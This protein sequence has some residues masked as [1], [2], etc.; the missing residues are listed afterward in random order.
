L[1]ATIALAV[2]TTYLLQHAPKRRY[3]F[4]TG[5]PFVFALVTTFTASVESIH[6]WWGKVAIETDS[7]QKFLMKLACVLAVIM[8][9]LTVIITLDTVRR[10]YV[11]LTENSGRK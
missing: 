9:T 6:T 2:G 1:L 3:A 11:L 8:L 7:T 4:C 5:I 10:W